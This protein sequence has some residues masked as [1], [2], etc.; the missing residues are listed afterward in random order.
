MT[1][2]WRIARN[3][4]IGLAAFIAVVVVAAIL[5]VQTDWF[6]NYVRQKII[7]ATEEGTGGRVEVG[8]FA[9]NWRALE[10]IVSD[11]VIHGKEPAGAEPFVRASRVQVNLRLFTSL[12]RIID[13][14][15]LGVEKP[16]VNIL[17]FA[18]GTTNIPEPKD[19]KPKSDK[20]ILDTVVDLAVDYFQ[21]SDGIIAYNSQKQAIDV[22]GNNLRAQLWY[23]LLTQ[24][25][26]GQVSLQPLYVVSGRNTPVVFTVTLP[27]VLERT[28][29]ALDNAKITT[30]ASELT[31]NG[32]LEDLNN[33]KVNARINGHLATVDLKNLGNLPLDL[34]ARNMP[35]AIQID[36]NAEIADNRIAV[37]G[38][39]IGFGNSNIEASGTLKDPQGNG[40]LEFK[41]RLALDELGRLAKVN[42]RPSGVI[43]A[44]GTAKLD[45]SNNY[46]VTGNIEGR[47]LAFS[48][49]AQRIRNVDLFTA[50]SLDPHR[51]DLKGLRLAALGGQFNGDVSLEDFA[52][53]RV[54][55]NLR[56]LDLQ[57]ASQALGQ[58]PLPY[59]GVVSGPIQAQGDLKAPGSKLAV[60]NAKLSIT[61]G[62]RGIPVSG[63]INAEYN[64]AANNIN[65]ADSYIA[66]PNTRL[67][68][69]GSLNNRLNLELNSKNLND[70][71]AVASPGKPVVTLEGGQARFVGSVTGG[72]NA[73]QISG[74]LAMNRF[75]VQGRRFDSLEAD[76]SAAKTQA[77]VS[78][79]LLQRGPMQARFDA[80]SGLQNWSPKPNQPIK[81][82]AS[83]RNGDLADVMVLAGQPPAGYSGGLSMDANVEGTI[84]NPT[85]TAD[86]QVLNGSLKSEPF[87]RLQARVNMSD[88]LITIPAAS[89]SAGPAQV[90]MSAEFRHPRDSMTTGAVHAHVQSNQV[91]LAQVR[92]L[93]RERPNTSGML[94]LNADVTGNLRQTKV[95]GKDE[96]EFLLTS[97]DAEAA[98]R[99]LRFE[100][101]TYGDI[102]AK[103]STSGQTVNYDVN[104][105]FAGSDIKVTGN[106]QLVPGYPTN[107]DA[108]LRNL[109]VEKLLVLAKRTEIPARGNLSGTAHFSGTMQ[110]PQGS[111][112]LDLANAV[113][114]DEPIDHVRA[115]VNYLA[116]RIDVPAFEVVSG[117]SRIE[118]T[119]RYDHP[120][121]SLKTGD[122][123]FRVNS[124]RIELARIRNVQKTRPG[125][126]GILQIAASG[127]AAVG[128]GTPQILLRDLN[129]DI[130]V[131]GVSA[132]GKNLGDLT[133]KAATNAGR[134]NFTLDSNVAGAAVEARGSAQLTGDYPV[135]A[136]LNFKNVLW[137]RLQPLI[138]SST[139]QPPSFDASTEG[140][141]T[142]SGPALKTEQLRASLR[143]P[144]LQV[145]S[146]ARPGSADRI[147]RIHNEGPIVASLDRGIIRIDSAHLVGP[148]TDINAKGTASL[149]QTKPVEMD[150]AA[151]TNIGLLQ[152]FSQDI[153][154][155]GNVLLSAS[156]RGTMS[157]P[158]VNGRLE[159][160]N[161]SINYANFPNGLENANGLVIFS[162]NT[163]TIRSMTAQS[164]GGKVTLSGFATLTDT[165]RLGLRAT[166]NGVRVRTQQ[167]VSIVAN[168]FVNVT[169][170]T[171]SSLASGVVSISRITYAPQ[172]DFGSILTRAAPPV[173]APAA[174][175]P[176]L[177]NMRLDI[178]VRT[179]SSTAVQASL[180]ENI[181]VEA[182]LRVR[183]TAARPGV[184][185]RVSITEGDLVFFGSKYR[186]SSGDIT[187]YNP[188]RIE[189]VL[190]VTLETQAKGV[191]VVLTVTGPIDNMKLSY[192]SD[193]PLQFQ[194]I[195][196]LLASGRTPTSDPTLLANQPSQPQQSFQQMGET[197]IVSK[198]IAD[199]VASRLQRVFGVSQLK[200]DPTFT[201]GSE[202][203]Q[204]RVT[205]QQQVATNLTFTYVTALNDP[206]TQVIR[207]EWSFNPRWSA[208]A[209]RDENGIVSVS[210]LYKKQFR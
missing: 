19:K 110:A 16:G 154:S 115:K 39:K 106:T 14:S 194:E 159:L 24:S 86:L 193:P 23:N 54:N 137:S 40:A 202:L 141:L 186:V 4:G 91:N 161:A 207:I 99:N 64:G 69:S 98:A 188:V 44:N 128:Q 199:P 124:S 111:V 10:A 104:S 206:N 190:N 135:N 42:A 68:L 173:Q 51:L 122:L 37:Q 134:L 38:L 50:V 142:V 152:T 200:I 101:Q 58:K 151:N 107:A 203:P 123:Q 181:Q 43:T 158:L 79:G 136:E 57:T 5:V 126:G 7:T 156:I 84:G 60:A 96:T 15:Y 62:R 94:N 157:K 162:G 32:A 187:F 138:G 3:V 103:A 33:P 175:N 81:A 48:Q 147:V 85:G 148:Q 133:M 61:P 29:V 11:F 9:F 30:P 83:V 146:L 183:G 204:A 130:G 208:V 144:T 114:Y 8:S 127:A 119:G 198:A 210:F 67:N 34:N 179:T 36:G 97:V 17:V 20:T 100:G 176:L 197:A 182:D 171:Q 25:Y 140:Q 145:S 195:V 209:N 92:T 131:T 35:S 56:N 153:Y 72:L 125:L 149:L 41:T 166:A 12:S 90:N 1:K 112:D 172:S 164:G 120:A 28:R 73:P 116:Q 167:G 47:N 31:I 108:N 150:I 27:V 59:D 192:T 95:N 105:N 170:T 109:P 129:A 102:A 53:Y 65:V 160:Q 189:P 143:V 177:D 55:G 185:G 113:L 132:Q 82:T 70:L 88:Q 118:L 89:I 87:D 169:G 52:R 6:R 71:L 75:A 80:T 46:Q 139:G 26:K 21:I 66:L 168:A 93:Q 201:S 184:L 63:R 191:N 180:A 155:S 76:L 165:L 174:P 196:S 77:S 205:L 18:D 117:P 49:G 13:I 45:A 178:R 121:A 2:P 78:N 74:H 22:K 163:A